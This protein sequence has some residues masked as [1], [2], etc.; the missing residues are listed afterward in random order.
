MTAVLLPELLSELLRELLTDRYQAGYK[1]TCWWEQ[2][3][4][5]P[6]GRPLSDSGSA[7]GSG[8][9]C[10]YSISRTLTPQVEHSEPI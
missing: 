6:R 3:S 9:Q 8:N 10:T 2:L 1:A 5:V 7:V 4:I